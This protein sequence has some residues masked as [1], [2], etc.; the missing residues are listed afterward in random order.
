M[1]NGEQSRSKLRPNKCSLYDKRSVK[2]VTSSFHYFHFYDLNL[3][4]F[5]KKSNEKTTLFKTDFQSLSK[6]YYFT[7]FCE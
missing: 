5:S 6:L 4:D 3:C 2:N 7:K 1:R